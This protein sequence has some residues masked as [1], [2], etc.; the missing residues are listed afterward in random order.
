[1]LV[2]YSD[3]RIWS[4]RFICRLIVLYTAGLE[5]LAS[6]VPYWILLFW[7]FVISIYARYHLATALGGGVSEVLFALF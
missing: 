7:T 2:G 3:H 5:G 1:M 6:G 4:A